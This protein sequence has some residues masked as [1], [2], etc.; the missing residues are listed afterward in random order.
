MPLDVNLFVLEE[1]KET[2]NVVLHLITE[3]YGLL[4]TTL[5]VFSYTDV[6]VC[7]YVRICTMHRIPFYSFSPFLYLFLVCVNK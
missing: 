7:V 6:C 3:V 1:K 2:G 4:I 5:R